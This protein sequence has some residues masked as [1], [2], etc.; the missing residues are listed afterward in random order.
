MRGLCG[1]KRSR[2]SFRSHKVD[3]LGFDRRPAAAIMQASGAPIPKDRVDVQQI[4]LKQLLHGVWSRSLCHTRVIFKPPHV[5]NHAIGTH[6]A[7]RSAKRVRRT[8]KI[9][10]LGPDRVDGTG[11]VDD[12]VDVR[13]LDADASNPLK[14][15]VPQKTAQ[16]VNLPIRW[17]QAAQSLKIPS[18]LAAS[19][20]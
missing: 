14:Q 3:T 11:P 20:C 4:V 7:F 18:M 5:E 12:H 19:E 2:Y 8:V 1:K 9:T 17:K 10:Q 15:Q 16:Q 6:L 13:R